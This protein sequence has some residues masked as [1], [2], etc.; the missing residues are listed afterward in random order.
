[1]SFGI[2]ALVAAAAVMG[3]LLS[4]S[5]RGLVP[6]VVGELAAGIVIGRTGFGWVDP[7]QPT[8]A[9]MAD[10]GFAMLMLAAGMHVPLRDARLLGA[11]RRGAA[12]ALLVAAGAVAGGVGVAELSGTGHA[13]V[14]AL[15]L[16]TGSAAV[17]LPVLREAELSG[18]DALVVMAQVTV[19]DVATIVA[20][21]MVLQPDRAARAALGGLVV[22][23]AALAILGLARLTKQRPPVPRLRKLSKQRGWAL[24]LRVALLA[25]F[26]LAYLATRIGTSVLI[27]GFGA[28]LIIAW[29]GGPKRLSRQVTGVGAGFLIPLFFVV[30]GARLDLR[31]LAERP[32]RL[33]VVGGL[34]AGSAIIHL[35]A[36]RLTGQRFPA[37]LVASAQ[38][39]VPAA[40]AALGLSEGVL[41]PGVAGAIVTAALGSLALCSV[42]VA[43]MARAQS[44]SVGAAAGPA[45]PSGVPEP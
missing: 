11:L 23:A 25:L 37:G 24:D 39:G 1:V 44:S 31:V 16:A 14:Y 33:I 2:L 7:D 45:A 3:P 5:G 6:V 40:V 34:L 43:L 15:L 29:V 10:V 22:A 13:S 38:L 32:S 17:V 20:L 30:L 35:V 36:A 12:A 26:V 27:A 4:A 41:D 28:G 8:L 21:P 42:G 19:A 9:F 18:P